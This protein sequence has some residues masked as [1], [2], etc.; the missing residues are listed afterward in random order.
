MRV[1]RAVR[2]PRGYLVF[3]KGLFVDQRILQLRDQAVSCGG[4]GEIFAGSDHSQPILASSGKS[5]ETV[6]VVLHHQEPI[7]GGLQRVV[8]SAYIV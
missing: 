3:E 5:T 6:P 8:Q 1:P 7:V 2:A 4:R